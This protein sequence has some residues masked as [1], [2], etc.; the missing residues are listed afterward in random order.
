MSQ[1][2]TL[3]AAGQNLDTL[4]T[5]KALTDCL[6]SIASS[7]FPNGRSTML[8]SP[9][10]ARPQRERIAMTILLHLMRF[11]RARAV[12]AGVISR[13]LANYPLAGINDDLL[14][15]KVASSLALCQPGV[16]ELRSL[17]LRIDRSE[18]PEGD[19]ET[20]VVGEQGAAVPSPRLGSGAVGRR[21]REESVEELALRRRRREAM[22][23][24]EGSQPLSNAD[25]IQREADGSDGNAEQLELEEQ[26]I[27]QLMDEVRIEDQVADDQDGRLN[28][29][30]STGWPWRYLY[31]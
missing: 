27:E 10:Q 17:G 8:S 13:W 23:I 24:H 20:W 25:I 5:L 12:E 28:S 15:S 19:A 30:L 1:T 29:P 18:P 31:R 14:L 9:T 7:R 22:I 11:A 6:C 26:Q 2:H 21:V 4:A 16:K 3:A